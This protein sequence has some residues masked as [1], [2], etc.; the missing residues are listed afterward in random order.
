MK[1]YSF[2]SHPHSV[3]NLPTLSVLNRP[4][5]FFRCLPRPKSDI[6]QPACFRSVLG[7]APGAV[8]WI[9]SLSKHLSFFLIMC[10]KYAIFLFVTD[11]SRWLSVPA[12]EEPIHLLFFLSM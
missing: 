8:P 5:Q 12:T 6:A 10:P 3:L 4:Q 11:L 2:L 9:I 1:R 7:R